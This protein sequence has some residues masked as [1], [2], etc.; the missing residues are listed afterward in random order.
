MNLLKRINKLHSQNEQQKSFV[1][2][3]ANDKRTKYSIFQLI[4]QIKS[5]SVCMSELNSINI[6]PF[7][8]EILFKLVFG[9]MV[10][11]NPKI[12]HCVSRVRN[13]IFPKSH[14]L[15]TP[16]TPKA[17]SATTK[18]NRAL[19]HHESINLKTSARSDH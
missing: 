4:V 13:S 1:I 16:S 17:L 6:V 10:L 8:A 2:N 15:R 12:L 14:F 19:P 9:E 18:W 7:L 11:T 5:S 3:Q